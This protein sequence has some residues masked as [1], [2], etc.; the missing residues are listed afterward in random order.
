MVV[1]ADIEHALSWHMV[2]HPEV[3]DGV[4]F[5]G[6]QTASAREE[7]ARSA[8]RATENLLATTKDGALVASEPRMKVLTG[9]RCDA[10]LV[11]LF[12]GAY[13]GNGDG[14]V[15]GKEMLAVDIKSAKLDIAKRCAELLRQMPTTVA[16]DCEILHGD[17]LSDATR[18]A[19][20]YRCHKK[21]V[22]QDAIRELG[23]GGG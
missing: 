15:G 10:R 23:S 2:F 17:A 19:V 13:A 1:F 12:A 4:G 9:G 5:L 7:A 21:E 22:L 16:R 20:S 3:W 8:V 14:V 11:S 6:D 18:A